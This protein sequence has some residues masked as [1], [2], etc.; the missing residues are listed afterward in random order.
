MMADQHVE[1]EVGRFYRVPSVRVLAWRG[2]TGW[3]PVI[4]PK[5]EDAEVVNFPWPHFHM[6][7]RFAP[8]RVF[9]WYQDIRGPSY[10]YG[11]VIQCPDR[12]GLKVVAEGPTPKLMKCKRASPPYPADVPWIAALT[13]Q[14]ACAKL[15]K[16]ACPHRGIP[17]SA[18]IRN[19]D[20]LTCP[21]HGLR[22]SAITGEAL[23]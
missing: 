16:G 7:W 23:P 17:V 20:V 4:G 5:H 21:G 10:V 13:K 3:L 9:G 14:F 12:H 8:E 18:M 2:F 6:D 15:I 19:G 22:W 11:A 1:Y